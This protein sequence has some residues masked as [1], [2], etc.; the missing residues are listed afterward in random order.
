MPN[1]EPKR[2]PM[3]TARC[4]HCA[5]SAQHARGATNEDDLEIAKT[6]RRLLLEHVR[7]AHPDLWS[8]K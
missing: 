2:D 7:E 3:A 5:W 6:L 4:H 1:D 8:R